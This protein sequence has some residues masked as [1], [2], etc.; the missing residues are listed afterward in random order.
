MVDSFLKSPVTSGWELAC[1]D[2][3]FWQP[4]QESASQLLEALA[5]NVRSD[6][7]VTL[8]C[9]SMGGLV[10][11]LAV[12]SGRASFVR[13]II[14]LGTPNHGTLRPAQWGLL[15]QMVMAGTGRLW[16]IFPSKIGVYDLTRVQEIFREAC[17]GHDCDTAATAV[18]YVTIPGR[19]YHMGRYAWERRFR[20]SLTTRILTGL[21]LLNEWARS[22][23]PGAKVD[24]TRPHDGIVPEA[25]VRL[26]HTVDWSEKQ[27]AMLN[28]G[29]GGD[30]RVR[31]LAHMRESLDHTHVDLQSAPSV[32][33]AVQGII[34]HDG[35]D[36]WRAADARSRQFEVHRNAQFAGS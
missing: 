29:P 30:A 20:G 21:T 27:A 31:H 22:S 16:G 17:P 10:A 34:E 2:Y 18:E 7:S 11:R 3:D 23:H 24:L 36:A 12:V 14:M 26:Q 1:F 33:A 15:G 4:M 25:S 19:F 9:H 32:V 35:V 5:A 6:S 28:P 13:R 8:V